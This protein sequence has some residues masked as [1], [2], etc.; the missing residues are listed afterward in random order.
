MSEI[1][2]IVDMSLVPEPIK[3]FVKLVH[4]ELRYDVSDGPFE[5]KKEI[6]LDF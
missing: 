5:G 2:Y 4:Q 3:V 6:S 1:W